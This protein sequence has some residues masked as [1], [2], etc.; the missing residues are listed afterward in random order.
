MQQDEQFL[1]ELVRG[2]VNNPNDVR[3][4]RKVDERG[5]LLTLYVNPADM[6]YVIGRAG[7][8]AEAI[9]RLVRTVGAKNNARVNVRIFEPEGSRGAMHAVAMHDEID[10]SAVD[11]LNI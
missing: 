2:L 1:L 8:T 4:E 3:V 9:R 7:K 6:G 10:T 11:N 5:V